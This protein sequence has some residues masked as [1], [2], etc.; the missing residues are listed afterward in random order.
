MLPDD[1]T[2]NLSQ[3]FVAGSIP[4]VSYIQ[5]FALWVTILAGLVSLVWGGISIL[6]LLFPRHFS[7]FVHRIDSDE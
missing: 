3:A 1:Q 5:D 4:A 7:A 6:K 2:K